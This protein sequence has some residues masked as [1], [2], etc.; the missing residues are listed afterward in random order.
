MKALN[1]LKLDFC[2][3]QEH[4]CYV[5]KN[6]LFKFNQIFFRTCTQQLFLKPFFQWMFCLP[7]INPAVCLFT[8][9]SFDPSKFCVLFIPYLIHATKLSL[10]LCHNRTLHWPS[11]SAS[12][13]K[14]LF[15]ISA[16]FFTSCS[17]VRFCFSPS[18]NSG[19]TMI[20]FAPV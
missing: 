19:I 8:R 20:K 17:F 16:K 12:P 10:R 2:N 11:V 13:Q 7:F 1:V 14:H 6:R 4:R 9:S 15:R 18:Y 3:E 5:S